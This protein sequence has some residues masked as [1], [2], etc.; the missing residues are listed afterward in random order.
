VKW[1]AGEVPRLTARPLS[2][3]GV[4]VLDAFVH[5]KLIQ[6]TTTVER[7]DRGRRKSPY[8]ERELLQ[9]RVRILRLLQDEDGALGQ[10][11][12][13][14]EE[15][16]YR[17]RSGNDYVMHRFDHTIVL[18]GDDI[19]VV[20]QEIPHLGRE[21]F[22]VERALGDS[23]SQPFCESQASASFACSVAIAR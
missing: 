4:R 12:L 7:F 5:L 23:C 2:G 11:Q 8:P 6:Q 3:V 9:W 21:G 22:V 19:A 16:P 10:G 13:T 20:A 18:D 17:P 14:G 1:N 15:Q